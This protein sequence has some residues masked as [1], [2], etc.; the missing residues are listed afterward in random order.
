V[1]RETGKYFEGGQTVMANA[2]YTD[3]PIFVKEGSIIPCGPEIQYTDEKP[4]DPIRLFVYTGSDASFSLYED[5]NINYDYEKGIFSLI[6]FKYDNKDRTLTIGNRQGEFP[7]MVETRTFEI[8]WITKQK[9]SDLNFQSVPDKSI[10]YDGSQLIIK[11][12]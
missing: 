6:T 11:M 5:E 1:S 12:E 4:A 9:P 8:V 2:P 10:V 3:I 7:G